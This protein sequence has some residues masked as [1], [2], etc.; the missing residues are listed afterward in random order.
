[1]D[2]TMI[3]YFADVRQLGNFESAEKIINIPISIITALGTVMIPHMSKVDDEQISENICDTYKLCFF[4]IYPII[5]GLLLVSKNFCNIFF[6]KEYDLTP[7]IINLLLSTVFFSCITNITRNN[8]LIPKSKDKIYVNSTICGAIVNFVLNYI[9]IRKYGAY[10][11]CVGTIAAE[12][13]VMMYQ[14]Y[15]TKNYINYFDNLKATMPFLFSSI[16]IGIIIYLIGLINLNNNVKI[17]IQ[18]LVSILVYLMLNIKYIKNEIFG[19]KNNSK[20]CIS[21]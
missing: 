17:V 6:G 7:T 18:V 21:D 15:K 1:M 5:I 13:S 16:V 20:E 11:A 19:K 3:G 4:M 12:F 14:V 8:F 2:K 9:F 10:G